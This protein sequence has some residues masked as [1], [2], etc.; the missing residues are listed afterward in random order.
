MEVVARWPLNAP[1]LSPADA[2]IVGPTVASPS[3]AQSVTVTPAAAYNDVSNR[4]IDPTIMPVNYV[5]R[6]LLR[7]VYTICRVHC[8]IQVASVLHS[9]SPAVLSL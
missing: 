7:Y 6:G 8:D 2:A 4:R 1:E 5:Q 3:D 9:R